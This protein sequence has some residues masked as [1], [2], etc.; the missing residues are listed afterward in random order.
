METTKKRWNK[1]LIYAFVLVV[2]TWATWCLSGN[3]RGILDTPLFNTSFVAKL[4]IGLQNILS[5]PVFQVDPLSFVFIYGLPFLFSVLAIY[6]SVRGGMKT[7]VEEGKQRLLG[8]IPSDRRG[9]IPVLLITFAVLNILLLWDVFV[10]MH[11]FE[12]SIFPE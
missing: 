6:L 1:D 11:L 10:A 7:P 8:F 3:I 9:I 12:P 2:L 4:Y 5:N